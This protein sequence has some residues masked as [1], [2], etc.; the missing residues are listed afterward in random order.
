MSNKTTR[1]FKITSLALQNKNSVFLLVAVIILFGAISYRTLPKEL[2]PE[3]NMP[4]VFIQTTYM[5]NPPEDIEN[6]I[7][8]PIEKEVKS[9]KGINELRSTSAR[10]ASMIFVE[11]TSKT[12]IKEALSDVKDAVDKAKSDLPSDLKIDPLVMDFDFSEFPILNINLAGDY[13]INELKKYAEYLED[14]IETISE[15]SKVEIKGIDDREIQIN[16]D[17]HKLD[18]F[19]LSFRDIESAITGENISMSGGEIKMGDTRRSIRIIGEYKSMDE[20]RNTIVKHEK[21]NIVYMRD[22]AEVMDTY[23][24]PQSFARQDKQTVVSVQVIKKSGEN[25]LNA[26]DQVFEIIDK[27]KKDGPIPENVKISITN[28]QSK[29]IR[30]QLH[31]L[32][33]SMIM[34]VIFVILV[35]Y[36]FLGLRNAIFVGLAIPMSMFLSF[37]VLG[38]MGT[39]INFIVLFSLILALG[40]LVDNAIVVVENIYRFVSKGFHVRKAAKYAVGEIAVPII[41]STATTLAAFFPLIFWQG[42]VGEFMKILPI[43][44]IIVLASS[45]VVALV[46]NPV[47]VSVFLKTN[48]TNETINRKKSYI[49]IGTMTGLAIILYIGGGMALPNLLIA[50]SILGL[51]NVLFLFDLAK[52]FQNVA[53]TKLED[54]YLRFIKYTLQGSKP[55]FFL[56]GTVFLLILSIMF[57]Q[58]RQPQTVFFP[59]NEPQ[60]INIIAEMPIGTDVTATNRNAKKF[61]EKIYK[62]IEEY[63]D[64][65]ESVQTTVGKGVTRQNQFSVGN[66]PNRALITIKFVDYEYRQGIETS[67]IMKQISDSFINKHPGV[68]FFIEKN[69]M[70]PPTGYPINI[71]FSGPSLDKIIAITDTAK[72]MV[73]NE[74]IEGIEDL[75]VDITIGSPELKVDI[76]REQARRF[77]MSTGQIAMNI[78][79]AL[80]GKEISKFKEGEDD[81]PI[82]L[83]MKPEYRYD[84]SAIMNQKITFRNN[85]GQLMQIPITSVATVKYSTS[86]GTV[87]RKDMKRVVTLYSNVIEGYNANKIN[88][89]LKQLLAG[90]DMPEGYDYSFTGEQQEQAESMDFMIRALMIAVAIILIIL[91][92][93]FNSF[94]KP[95][96]II[97][98]VLFS[99]IGVLGGI[100]SVKMD[101]VIIMT[102]IGIISLAGIV[103]NNAIVLI[104]YI[105]YLKLKKRE[106]KGIKDD[107]NLPIDIIID[108]II[109]AGKT[110]LR[111]V[112]LTAITTILG[113]LPMALGMNIDFEGL[114]TDLN[115]NIYFGGDNAIFWGP[116]AWTV[117][118]GLTFATFLTLVIVPAMYLIANRIKISVVHFFE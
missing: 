6:L 115:P 7:T 10:D 86:Y 110:R 13:S 33:N 61:E 1:E 93:Q 76:N 90:L 94:I 96:I 92:S 114:I 72:I 42:I 14:E 88:E 46:I 56:I 12:D 19:Q 25:L 116:M 20:I 45:L 65:V 30:S 16:V 78:R 18:A 106:E 60:F 9:I 97:A 98:S 5:G 100:A 51:M 53:L 112:L 4:T 17:Q 105:D 44:L 15:I 102:G 104:D 68:E 11:F 66:T 21:G 28:D 117:I 64:I 73:A 95:L 23:A 32:E 31:N 54:I 82:Q 83:R 55:V 74:G 48:A 47:I 69:S 8:R 38:V 57:F 81:Y 70:G 27:A 84:L 39:T 34:G 103:V 35:L 22:V 2:F 58:F 89:R 62:I 36:F 24:E 40:M 118:F 109:R 79:T 52:W 26:T 3:V 87:R 59:V 50:F 111:P 113:L 29:N 71:E 41:S 99:T 80:F 49:A 101:F 108:C 77:G 63:K 37:V 67:K 75:N 43:T 107:N 85:R 91:V